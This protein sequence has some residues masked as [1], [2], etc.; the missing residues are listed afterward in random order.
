VIPDREIPSGV[1]VTLDE[2]DVRAGGLLE[3]LARFLRRAVAARGV[4]ARAPR[5]IAPR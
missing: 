5:G 3:Q 1:R 4:R 2:L